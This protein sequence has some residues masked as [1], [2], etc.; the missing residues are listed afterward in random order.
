MTSA[1]SN[2]IRRS[3]VAGTW[4]PGS[5]SAL[6]DAIDQF[7]AEVD[8]EPIAGELHG[9]ISPHAGYSYSGRVAAHSYKQLEGRSY[10][11]VVV[12]SPVHQP[13]GG[14]YLATSNDY[15]ET[16]LGLVEVDRDTLDAVGREV[17]FSYLD[18]DEE[19]SL[20]IQLPFLQHLLGD[21]SLVPI[22]MGEQSL[23]SCRELSAALVKVLEGQ[24]ALLVA[25]SD[26]AHL[27]DY[28]EVIAHDQQ[29]QKYVEEFDPEGLAASLVK[30]EAQ[31][32]GGGPIITVMLTAK[33][34]GADRAT[35]LSYMNSGDV[36]G[37]RTPGQYTVGYLAAALY[38]PT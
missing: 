34:R 15:Y 19:H 30:G 38:K 5:P 26:L 8:E 28:R 21:F 16:P 31:A 6:A 14:Q 29:V 11:T 3:V 18:W 2:R 23:G 32:C 35:V 17:Q 9:L 20:E 4:Y 25:S 22:M 1:V 36:T 13:Y 27:H 12:V 24:E 37:I 33:A 10:P 7:L